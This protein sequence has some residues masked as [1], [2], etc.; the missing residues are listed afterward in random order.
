MNIEQLAVDGA[1][2]GV[3]VAGTKVLTKML[4]PKK[5]YERWYPLAPIVLAIPLAG[6]RY[7]RAGWV[8]AVVMTLVYGFLAGHSYK[9][10]KT[11]VLGQ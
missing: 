8:E 1:I 9:T 11:T 3:I 5:A 2:V 4:D 7:W 6:L 10:G